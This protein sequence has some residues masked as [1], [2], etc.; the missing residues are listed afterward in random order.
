MSRKEFLAFG[1]FLI[2]SAFGITGLIKTLSSHA[3][4]ATSQL[5]PEQG[6]KTGNVTTLTDTTASGGGAI[7]FGTGGTVSRDQLVLGQYKP[8]AATTGVIP[9]TTLTDV[10]TATAYTQS[11][12]A[13]SPIII[14]NKRFLNKVNINGCSY[15]TFRNCEFHS[16]ANSTTTAAI[17]STNFYNSNL[18]FED[19]LITQQSPLSEG[20]VGVQGGHNST[21]LRCEF[22]DVGDGIALVH[23]QGTWAN[24]HDGP[25]NLTV[26]GC[27]FHDLAYFSPEPTRAP[28]DNASHC[29][30][31]QIRGGSNIV[32]R[33]STF[34]AHLDPNIGAASQPSADGFDSSGN[35]IHISGNKYYPDMNATSMMMVSP[36]LAPFHDIYVE[37]NWIDGGSYSINLAGVGATPGQDTNFNIRNN[38][39]G[40]S[41]RAGQTATVIG[42]DSFAASGELHI[43]GNTYEDNGAPADFR[44]RG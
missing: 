16:V 25:M 44:A 43:S 26:L 29:D 12:T 21:F 2:V 1:G 41:M 8:S 30:C 23:S 33:Y 7:E 36:Y 28:D 17:T 18:R 24:A 4:T 39:W 13:D 20:A 32:V 11:G 40:R 35:P 9:G 15:L 5:E 37:Y 22:K 34:V 14:E 42:L 3:V 38:K 19:C 6:T 10:T 27:Y 31:I